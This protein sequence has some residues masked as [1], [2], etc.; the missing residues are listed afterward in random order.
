MFRPLGMLMII[1]TILI[2]LWIAMKTR[3]HKLEFAHNL[4]VLCWISANS[5]WM[6][7]EFYAKDGT[8]PYSIVLFSLGFIAIGSY[9]VPLLFRKKAT[10]QSSPEE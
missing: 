7:G 9:Y 10:E 6:Y 5:T 3:K 4:A 2:A 8:R 1:P